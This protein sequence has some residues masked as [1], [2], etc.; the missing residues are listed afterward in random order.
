MVLI[1][2]RPDLKEPLEM[3]LRN[4]IPFLRESRFS[5]SGVALSSSV[6]NSFIIESGCRPEI[7]L[8]SG[9]PLW[10]GHCLRAIISW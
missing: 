7:L 3:K 1:M 5:G 6:D 10:P 2:M 8:A 4:L 9:G